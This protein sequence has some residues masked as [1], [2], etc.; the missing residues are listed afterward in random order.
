MKDPARSWP[1]VGPKAAPSK[2]PWPGPW[3]PPPW[4]WPSTS[5][6]FTI[7]PTSSTTVCRTIR[8]APVS[9][10]IST[11]QTWQPLGK[12][13]AGAVKAQ[14]SLKPRP[15]VDPP[16]AAVAAVGEGD[17]GRGEGRGLAEAGLHPGRELAGLV[18]G[19]GHAGQRH[20][21][22]GPGHAEATV[23]EDDVLGRG[24][25]HA[26]GDA[27]AAGDDLVGGTEY[28]RAP[29]GEGTRPSVAPARAE[30]VAVAPQD[31]DTRGLDTQPLA[32]DLGKGRLVALAHRG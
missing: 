16:L 29:D 25:Q 24:L 14:V 22:I 3:P 27:P 13:T 1:V 5:M 4:I 26:G 10:S 19:A 20:A 11:S 28:G 8:T 32:D 15:P 12:V 23:A 17:G 30:G 21:A 2:S 18:G 7:V 6:G 31:L 9:S